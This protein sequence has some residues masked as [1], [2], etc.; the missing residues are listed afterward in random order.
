M[1]IMPRETLSILGKRARLSYNIYQPNPSMDFLSDAIKMH[2][3]DPVI[4]VGLAMPILG[5]GNYHLAFVD[6]SNVGH[7][8][9]DFTD[10][11]AEHDIRLELDCGFV[12][13]MFS[14][15]EIGRMRHKGTD[16][17][18]TCEPVIDIG[19]DLSVWGMLPAVRS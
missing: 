10:V 19:P 18:T 9:A 8:L 11:C 13:C 15:M 4:R 3:L 12:L 2:N 5:H 6:Y 17:K 7:I 16:V 14:P 1:G